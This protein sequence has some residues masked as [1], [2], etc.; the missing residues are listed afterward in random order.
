MA[1]ELLE[2]GFRGIDNMPEKRS[3]GFNDFPVAVVELRYINDEMLIENANTFFYKTAGCIDEEFFR[4]YGNNYRAIILDDDWEKVKR[5][6]DVALNEGRDFF[7]CEYRV[8]NKNN[9]IFWRKINAAKMSDNSDDGVLFLCVFNDITNDKEIQIELQ[10]EKESFY[11]IASLSNAQLFEYEISN[12]IMY[13]ISGGKINGFLEDFSENVYKLDIFPDDKKN[14]CGR[15]IDLLK[16]G[17]KE[18][19]CEFRLK[20]YKGKN[21]WYGFWA[22]TIFDKNG[23]PL[24]VIGKSQN[25]ENEKR[26]EAVFENI[27]N[28]D[29]LTKL[30]NREYSKK[31]IERKFDESL[32]LSHSIVVV[33]IDDFSHIN[34]SFGKVFCDEILLGVTAGL[35]NIFSDDDIIG[36]IG[37]DEFIIFID[38]VVSEAWLEEILVKIE[39]IFKCSR[40]CEKYDTNITGSIGAVISKKG[41]SDFEGNFEKANYALYISKSVEKS[42]FHIFNDTD[43]I[44]FINKTKEGFDFGRKIGKR[45]VYNKEVVAEREFYYEIAEFAFDVMESTKNVDSAINI[46]F[47]RVGRYFNLSRVVFREF[48]NNEGSSCFIAY[49]WCNKPND[50]SVNN[51]KVFDCADISV[52]LSK[53]DENGMFIY[54][55]YPGFERNLDAKAYV[56][57]GVKSVL[58]FVIFEGDRASGSISFDDHNERIWGQNEIRALKMIVKIISAYILKIRAF[59]EAQATVERITKYDSVTGVMKFE[60]FKNEVVKIL[61]SDVG[62]KYAVVYSDISNF[63]Y[64][65]KRYGYKIGD[66]LLKN[67]VMEMDESKFSLLITSRIFTD[68]FVSVIK[69]DDNITA[70]NIGEVVDEYNNG[71]I[72]RQKRIYDEINI[73]VITGIYI[74]NNNYPDIDKDYVNKLIDSANIARKYAKS[75]LSEK[76]VFFDSNMERKMKMQVE[77][78]TSMEKALVNNEFVVV[79]QPKVRLG[80]SN[81]IVGAE[82]L[83]RWVKNDGKIIPPMDFIPLFEKNGFVV[84]VDFCVYEQVCKFLSKRIKENKKIVPISVNVSRVHLE[85]GDFIDKIQKLV[86][87]Y[88]I[89]KEYLEFELTENIFLE[90]FDKTIEVMSALRNMNFKVSM[91]D[92]GSGYSS[93]NFLKKLPVDVLKMDK[94]FLD[95]DEIKDNDEIVIKSVIDMAKRMRITVLCE[96]VETEKQA[97]FLMDAGCDLAQGYYFSKPVT[98]EEFKAML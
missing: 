88:N 52:F 48:R 65:N 13:D 8:Q 2:R 72:A 29:S 7:E 9:D 77:I 43:V 91:D 25:I 34:N 6:I 37:E 44:P 60:S 50:L 69:L 38:N 73:G 4:L 71:F 14:S 79:F 3:F 40:V 15:L 54:S 26:R 78:L 98:A 95:N 39:D 53:C 93:L 24:R 12:D 5:Q 70:D 33:D 21:E 76:A 31:L 35:K 32:M 62:G 20:K 11:T 51:L 19:Y 89:P 82:A 55:E 27:V 36:K 45:F 1:K 42:K 92:F 85:K 80:G 18:F 97:K 68:N 74:F 59:R 61:Y 66:E 83:V 56:D 87:K 67:F 84:N 64:I 46:L 17:K 47:D 30:F 63:K 86:E 28:I 10:K 90:N 96:G 23:V 41:D 57:F 81:E 49:H 16:S 94:G 58:R 22:K 75:I